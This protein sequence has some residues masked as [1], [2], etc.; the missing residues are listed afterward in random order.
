MVQFNVRNDLSLSSF[1][2]RLVRNISPAD[3]P[4]LQITDL[5][6]LALNSRSDHECHHNVTIF[7]NLQQFT[8]CMVNFY[9]K[10]QPPVMRYSKIHNEIALSVMNSQCDLRFIH[11]TIH[12][13]SVIRLWSFRDEDW[14]RWNLPR[15]RRKNRIPNYFQRTRARQSV[16]QWD[17]LVRGERKNEDKTG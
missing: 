14:K 12:P 7:R 5:F 16:E 8:T 1:W 4:V 17:E 15:G 3:S 13:I 9:T 6:I 10:H 11:H 2:M